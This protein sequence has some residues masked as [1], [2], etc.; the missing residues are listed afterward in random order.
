MTVATEH[1]L[2]AGSARVGAASLGADELLGPRVRTPTGAS[3]AFIEALSPANMPDYA[4]YVG[5]WLAE[6]YDGLWGQS[7]RDIH[8]EWDYDD[9]YEFTALTNLP[10]TIY[11]GDR[12]SGTSRGRIGVHVYSEPGTYYPKA[13]LRDSNG[14]SMVL[15]APPVVVTSADD[16]Y[17]GSMTRC[18]SHDGDFTGAPAGATLITT[19]PDGSL[20]SPIIFRTSANRRHL[21]KRGSPKYY[22]GLFGQTNPEGNNLFFGAFGEGSKPFVEMSPSDNEKFN[23]SEYLK[24][25]GLAA[26]TDYDP[27][28]PNDWWTGTGLTYQDYLDA[29]RGSTWWK[30]VEGGEVLTD[31]PPNGFY[32]RNCL[33][34]LWFDCE[35][36][37]ANIGIRCDR[38]TASWFIANT[39]VR[40]WFDF[41]V[42]GSETFTP[43]TIV[44]SVI[45][46]PPGV[47]RPALGDSV[48]SNRVHWNTFNRISS[49]SGFQ[50]PV[51]NWPRHAPI[52]FGTRHLNYFS[53]V[54][55]GMGGGHSAD[56]TNHQPAIRA[57]TDATIGENAANV[58]I[59]VWSECHV[60]G[61]TVTQGV[62]FV[63]YVTSNRHFLIDAMTFESPADHQINALHNVLSL[64]HTNTDVVNCLFL[65]R[66]TD[67]NVGFADAIRLALHNNFGGQDVDWS[68]SNIRVINN[69]FALIEEAGA[70]GPLP[71]FSFSAAG[72]A[73]PPELVLQ[74]N[75][76]ATDSQFALVPDGQDILPLS[77]IDLTRFAVTRSQP[78]TGFVPAVDADG[79]VR[80]VHASKGWVE[81]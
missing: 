39:E 29:G 55:F 57:F 53:K 5:W 79:T 56:G 45:A 65:Y 72:R 44:G 32:A 41:G 81:P 63:P 40:N 51:P 61:T 77:A 17:P 73:L 21:F 3:V 14:N 1:S 62:N 66:D 27:A 49:H 18:Y 25:V 22:T 20:P 6:G 68:T 12:R 58:P 50:Q 30:N 38:S 35:I 33:M 54:Y 43:P 71:L 46:Q 75:I 48:A 24:F 69:T 2:S 31:R 19:N 11:V 80:P 10:D 9:D 36:V 34:P 74:N 8:V 23:G 4:P 67:T 78:A 16:R 60:F 13:T 52:R 28:A 15:H 26:G 37:G 76:V 42:F 64:S 47:Q 59:I 7:E 70:T